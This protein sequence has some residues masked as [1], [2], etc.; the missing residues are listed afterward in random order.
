MD[1]NIGFTPAE[2]FYANKAAFVNASY[3]IEYDIKFSEKFSLP[4]FGSVI[5][6]PSAEKAFVVVGIT[7]STN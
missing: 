6:N 2:S 1:L 3:K 4:V 7:L 5:A